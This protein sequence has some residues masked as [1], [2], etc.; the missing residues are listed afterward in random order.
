MEYCPTDTMLGDYFT[1]PTQGRRYK[2]QRRKIM[3]LTPDPNVGSQECV[4]IHTRA[5]PAR[6]R[7]G[8]EH[9]LEGPQDDPQARGI[10]DFGPV[11]SRRSIRTESRGE[12]RTKRDETSAA[13]ELGPRDQSHR[14]VSDS[15]SMSHKF[16]LYLEAARRGLNRGRKS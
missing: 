1:K 4:G 9:S 14:S 3:N 11:G 16:G 13:D 6:T 7:D 12:T 10:A 15:K 8:T 2:W 5:E